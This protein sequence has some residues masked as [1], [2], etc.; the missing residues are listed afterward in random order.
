MQTNRWLWRHWGTAPAIY[1]T[2]VY[3]S[4]VAAFGYDAAHGGSNIGRV[5]LL[6]LVTLAT[7]WLA[8]VFAGAL[9][10]HGTANVP[11]HIWE[12]IRHALFEST[13]MLEAAVVPSI[14]LLLG[15]LGILEPRTAVLLSLWVTVGVLAVLGYIAFSVRHRSPLVRVIG[16]VGTAAFGLVAV[17][18]EVL[19]H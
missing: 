17:G 3:S 12:S 15:A 5:L 1:G 9:A 7:F 2:I 11:T 18:L 6:S 13:G 19:V 8:H 14:P 4:L 16:A 10:F